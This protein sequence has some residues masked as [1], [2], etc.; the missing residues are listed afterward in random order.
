MRRPASRKTQVGIS[1]FPFLA[2]LICT[3]GALIV[4]LILVVQQARVQADT[5][6]DQRR[7]T[8]SRPGPA[9]AEEAGPGG[10]GLAVAARGPGTTA[11]AN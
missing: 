3:M 8:A 6:A 11:R 10:R 9:R 4:L 7:Q 2:V 1:L 5:V